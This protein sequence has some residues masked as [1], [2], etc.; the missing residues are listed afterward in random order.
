MLGRCASW[1]WVYRATLEE[2]C[3]EGLRLASAESSASTHHSV[4]HACNDVT[5]LKMTGILG[6]CCRGGRR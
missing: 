3:G 4:R 1:A 5:T 6:R 2:E